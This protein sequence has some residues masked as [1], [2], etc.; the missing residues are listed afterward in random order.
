MPFVPRGVPPYMEK[1]EVS[2]IKVVFGSEVVHQSCGSLE[3]PLRL[4]RK[5]QLEVL[6]PCVWLKG[7]CQIINHFLYLVGGSENLEKDGSEVPLT[8]L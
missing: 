2:V 8:T 3:V 5:S 1:A 6:L 4:K 7:K